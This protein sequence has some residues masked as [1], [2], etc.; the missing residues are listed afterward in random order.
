[1][2]EEEF[3]AAAPMG[4]SLKLL[5]AHAPMRL[6]WQISYANKQGLPEVYNKAITAAHRNDILIFVHDDVWLDHNVF[7]EIVDASLRHFNVVGVAGNTRLQRGQPGWAFHRIDDG[8]LIWDWGH[9]SGAVWHGNIHQTPKLSEYGPYPAPCELMDGVFFATKAQTLKTRKVY[10]DE[11]FDFHFYDLDFCR[12]ARLAGLTLGTW[13]IPLTHE[14]AGD[15][16]G[17]GWK[18]NLI[19]YRQKWESENISHISK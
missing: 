9:L 15:F 19:L 13:E 17:E 4:I 14:S 2:T 10:F 12:T 7:M 11:L 5:K 16:G 1:M 3:W 6:R 18:K 8:K